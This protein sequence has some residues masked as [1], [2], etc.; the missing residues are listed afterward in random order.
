MKLI[1]LLLYPLTLQHRR[2]NQGKK[3]LA[4]QTPGIIG[5][6]VL[7][8]ALHNTSQ[9]RLLG[10]GLLYKGSSTLQRSRGKSFPGQI[11]VKWVLWWE[12]GKLSRPVLDLPLLHQRDPG[13]GYC[14]TRGK[15]LRTRSAERLSCQDLTSEDSRLPSDLDQIPVYQEGWTEPSVLISTNKTLYAI[16]TAPLFSSPLAICT[17]IK[18]QLLV[19]HPQKCPIESQSTQMIK[20]QIRCQVLCNHLQRY[21]FGRNAYVHLHA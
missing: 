14:V 20:C 16:K 2:A 3:K 6:V 8:G 17:L 7:K 19:L 10:C 13:P 18:G 1:C 9:G 11:W 12:E 5:T 4:L 21:A 15:S